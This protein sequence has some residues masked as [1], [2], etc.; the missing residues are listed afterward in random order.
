M[1]EDVTLG[2]E[3]HTNLVVRASTSGVAV[4]PL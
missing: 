4:V 1:V 2:L 3:D